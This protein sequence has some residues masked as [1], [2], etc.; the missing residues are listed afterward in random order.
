MT[1]IVEQLREAADEI[2]EL[3]TGNKIHFRLAEIKEAEIKRLRSSRD[4]LREALKQIAERKTPY[5]T[6][7][8]KEIAR[9]ALKGKE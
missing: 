2:E 9:A 8:A 5:E 1:D 7:W 4:R 6:A 3:R